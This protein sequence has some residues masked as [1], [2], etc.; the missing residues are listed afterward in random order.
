MK[1]IAIA[2]SL[3]FVL[4]ACLPPPGTVFRTTLTGPDQSDTLP[5]A[6]GDQTA[7]V[8][9]IEQAEGDPTVNA[10]ILQADPTDS[11]ALIVRWL[12]GLCDNDVALSLAP[13]ESG[14]ALHLEV[15]GKI[16]LG[17]PAVGVIRGL[18]IMTSKPIR[19]DS[20]TVSGQG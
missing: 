9:G 3:V 5:I 20:I 2:L 11:N 12:G 15:H 19:V 1:T 16:G 18:R 8:T 14:Y 13:T 6:L 4:A 10:P 17:C 7:L